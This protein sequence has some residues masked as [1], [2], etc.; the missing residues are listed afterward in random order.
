[1]LRHRQVPEP[2][3]AHRQPFEVEVLRLLHQRADGPGCSRL[4]GGKSR[5]GWSA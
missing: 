2:Q 4:L 1:V 5:T 3:L